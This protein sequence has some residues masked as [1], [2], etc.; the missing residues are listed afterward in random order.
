MHTSESKMLQDLDGASGGMNLYFA[1]LSGR[2]KDKIKNLQD[3]EIVID[4]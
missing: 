3:G 4:I 1:D 2:H